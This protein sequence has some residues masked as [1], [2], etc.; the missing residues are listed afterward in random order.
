[1]NAGK[2]G[3]SPGLDKLCLERALRATSVLHDG[4]EDVAPQEQ[5][6]ETQQNNGGDTIAHALACL[7]GHATQGHVC[8]SLQLAV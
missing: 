3:F 7:D 8:R 5:Q 1:M 4:Y 2:R 6:G